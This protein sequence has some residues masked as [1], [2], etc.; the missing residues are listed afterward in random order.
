MAD[1]VEKNF[2]ADRKLTIDFIYGLWFA[3]VDFSLL[4]PGLGRTWLRPGTHII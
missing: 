2:I 3:H 4:P 1:M